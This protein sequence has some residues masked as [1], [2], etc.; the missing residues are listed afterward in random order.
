MAVSFSSTLSHIAPLSLQKEGRVFARAARAVL[1]PSYDLSIVFVG[2]A[3]SR[4]L[5]RTYRL[6]DKPTNV[7]SF[8]LSKQSGEIYLNVPLAVREANRF[9]E[10]PRRHACFLF[11][12]GLLHLKGLDHGKR[13]EH[14]EQQLMKKF[15]PVRNG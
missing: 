3:R 13:M 7:L 5:N 14:L 6:K 11:V 12:H 9:G 15:F 10:T 4:T 2:D 1:G 8:P